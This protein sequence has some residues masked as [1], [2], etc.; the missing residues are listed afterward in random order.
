MNIHRVLS[1]EDAQDELNKWRRY[2]NHART[3]L[4][5]NEFD[6]RRA[7]Q[8]S[9]EGE[10]ADLVLDLRRNILSANCLMVKQ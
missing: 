3:H 5:L 1:L 8:K 10:D 4:S 7:H 9:Q 2:H 6:S